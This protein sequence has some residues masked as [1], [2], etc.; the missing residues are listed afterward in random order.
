MTSLFERLGEEELVVRRELDELR[1]EITAAE[2]HLIRLTITRDT[3]L[4][5]LDGTPQGV[6]AAV[7][8][9]S[10]ASGEGELQSAAT[11]ATEPAPP[12][13][14][15]DL[16]EGRMRILAVLEKAEEPLKVKDITA[17]IGEASS[18]ME[19]TRSR[20]KRLAKESRAVEGPTG[21]FAIARTADPAANEPHSP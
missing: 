20:L 6:N 19:T 5:L 8:D 4:S 16:D 11:E 1:A 13:G 14:P 9:G 17:A 15:L 21:W 18:R 3:L 10:V 2:E 12:P 7:F